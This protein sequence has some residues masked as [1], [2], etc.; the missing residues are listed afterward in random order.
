MNIEIKYTSR[1]IEEIVATDYNGNTA[2]I[3]ICEGEFLMRTTQGN[4]VAFAPEEFRKWAAAVY[5]FSQ[6]I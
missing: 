6:E 2:Y 1:P 4:A 5:K 3:S